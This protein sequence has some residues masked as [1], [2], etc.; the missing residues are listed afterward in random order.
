MCSGLPIDFNECIASLIQKNYIDIK[1]PHSA[2]VADVV[3][4][5][6]PRLE[7]LAADVERIMD[8]ADFFERQN[9]FWGAI[10]TLRRALE[11]VPEKSAIHYRLARLEN[12]FLAHRSEAS[13]LMQQAI[14]LEPKNLEYQEFMTSLDPVSSDES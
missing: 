12:G 3:T 14:G 1:S 10:S 4:P 8:Q 5:A 2:S 11:I 9:N 6:A 13:R 7:F